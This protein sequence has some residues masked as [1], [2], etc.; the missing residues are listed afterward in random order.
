MSDRRIALTGMSITTPIA[1]TLDGY[2]E[3]L[4]AGRSA[5]TRWR[6]IPS[7]RIYAKVG[8]DLG[9]YDV[10]GAV[11]G[12]EGEVEEGLFRR[13]RKLSSRAPWSTSVAMIG[14][15]RAAIDAG[16][17]G[18][19]ERDDSC[20]ILGGHNLTS[21]YVYKNTLDFLEEPDF[22]DGLMSLHSLDTDQASSV[23]EVLG[24][25]GPVYTVG[26]ACASGNHALRLAVDEIRHHG[27]TSAFV[28]GPAVDFSP[29][30]LHAMALMGAISHQSFNDA[31]EQASRPF[32]VRR[33]GFVPSQAGAVLVLEDWDH[34][35]RRGARIYAE[36]VG[37]EANA[38]ANHEPQPSGE[39]QARLMRRLLRQCGLGPERIDYIN[40]HATSTPLGDVTEIASI[41][42]V[43][44]AHAHKLKINATKSMLGHATWS[45]PL[46]ELVAAVL[47]MQ[48]GRLHPSI[49]VDALDPAI[50]LDVC[51][52]GPVSAAV[53]YLMKTSF[54]FGGTN[55]I[56]ILRHP[57]AE[58]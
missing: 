10:A 37:V 6:T 1:D 17:I 15:V 33:E 9:D 2:L 13:L 28:V 43:F 50:D 52:D 16:W 3:A 24:T 48:A 20:V 45:A 41:K 51:S 7:E 53:G 49:N 36:V 32:D 46:V 55:C 57:E 23:S 12:L 42:E 22:I 30:D 34:A 38:D 18:S 54:G 35:S 14:A 39:G 4:L 25:R 26:G 44:G 40:A 8:G 27:M 58:R 31:P 56:T 29:V 19:C 21:G 11:A 47:Q 5:I